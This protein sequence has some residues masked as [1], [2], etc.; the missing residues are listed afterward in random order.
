MEDTRISLDHSSNGRLQGRV[1]LPAE[2]GKEKETANLVR[3]WGA[4]A[5]RDSD[6]TELSQELTEMATEVYSTI[7]LVRADQQ[8]NREHPQYLPEKY[9]LSEPVTAN[10]SQI[11]IHLMAGYHQQKYRLDTDHEPKTYWEVVD[12]TTGTVV[13]PDKWRLCPPDGHVHIT[14]AT[15]FHVYTVSFLAY[16]V[17]DSTSMYNHLVNKWTGPHIVSTDPFHPEAYNHL[18]EFFDQWLVDHP[19]TD[20][21][22]LTSL[23]YHFTLD[24]EPTG[25]DKYRDWL[26]YTDCVSPLALDHFARD[27]GY[28]L[29]PEDLV[30][31]G[32]YNATYRVPSRRYLDWMDFVQKFVARYCKE[33]VARVHRAGKKA[34]VFW[35]DHWI[36]LEPYG[37]RY[38]ELELDIS[39][40]ACEDGVALRRIADSPGPETK[41]IRLY[42]YFFPDVFSSDGG[43]LAESRRNW[44][45]IRRALVRRCVDRIGYGGYL[46]LALKFTDF[47]DHVA[48]LC[49][50]FRTIVDR[51]KKT[52]PFTGPV[53]VAV[54]TAWGKLRSWINHSGPGQKFHTGRA[55]VVEITGSNLLQ[56]LSG[57]AVEVRFISFADIAERGV[58][59][60]IEV[61]I[62]DGAAGTAWSGGQWWRRPEITAEIRRWVHQGGGFIGCVDPSACEYQ[63]RFYQLADIMG[64]QKEVGHSINTSAAEPT[65]PGAHYILDDQLDLDDL[66]VTESH[67]YPVSHATTVL[68]VGPSGHIL[69]AANKFGQGR[70]VYLAALP[71]SLGNCRLLERAIFWVAQKESCLHHWFSSNCHTGCAAFPETGWFVVLNH[72]DREQTTTVSDQSDQQ[73]TVTLAPCGSRWLQIDHFVQQHGQPS[74]SRSP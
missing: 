45:K 50:E 70:S 33:L 66:A 13:D 39:I 34:A 53:R 30:D 37:Q 16:L 23:A 69:V 19:Q 41:E 43:P 7:C 36:G 67:V 10:N 20:V 29:R 72:T 17:W 12:R 54:L 63:G 31:Q 3:K 22:R 73:I 1:T 46:S 42:P 58:P 57:L 11:D 52:R 44:I 51:T 61:I 55:D 38:Q 9:L 68:H 62:N 71:Y 26:G 4:D 24:S 56:C 18:I 40:G 14:G 28:R 48:D 6:G 5:V 25:R 21:A 65:V 15:P 49:E 35:G 47:V 8:W 60:D 32:Y 59:S 74:A 27:T 2:S 64:V